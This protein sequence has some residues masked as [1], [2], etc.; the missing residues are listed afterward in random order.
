MYLV[1]DI[2]P[3]LPQRVAVLYLVLDILPV[4]PQGMAVLYLVLDIL[5]VL[6][7]G[8][9]SRGHC[10]VEKARIDEPHEDDVASCAELTRL[11]KTAHAQMSP[12]LIGQ[13]TVHMFASILIGQ[14]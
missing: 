1:L 13:N 3:V 7:Q 5:P 6:P 4:L 11:V 2:L 12:M 9:V 8:M 10:L 14:Y